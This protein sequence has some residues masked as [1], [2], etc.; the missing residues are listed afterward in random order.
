M[1]GDKPYYYL[2]MN[3]YIA[4]KV[5]KNEDSKAVNK[6]EIEYKVNYELFRLNGKSRKDVKNELQCRNLLKKLGTDLDKCITKIEPKEEIKITN[7][8]NF[9][10]EE[11]QNIRRVALETNEKTTGPLHSKENG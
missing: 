3:Q 1:I 7:D 8:Y 6:E 10:K 2:P 9:V 5:T 4:W 11:K